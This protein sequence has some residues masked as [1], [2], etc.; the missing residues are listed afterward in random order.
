MSVTD[1]TPLSRKRLQTVFE[2]LANDQKLEI[3]GYA[4]DRDEFTVTELKADLEIAHTTA[5]EYCRD[6]HAA[7][8]LERT[9]GKPARYAPIDFDLH[10]S[11]TSI[12]DAIESESETIEYALETYGDDCID[13]VLEVWKSVEAGERTYR[14][15]SEAVGMAHADFLRVAQELELLTR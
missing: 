7:G 6:L 2:Q 11:L 1:D 15:A 9:G 3:L 12:A 4:A 5:H 8:L 13:D 10:L 14:E